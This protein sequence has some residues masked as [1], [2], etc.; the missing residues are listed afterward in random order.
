M[1]RRPTVFFIVRTPQGLAIHG[2]DL[3]RGFEPEVADPPH[4]TGFKFVGGNP[5]KDPAKRIVRGNPIRQGQEFFKPIV[6]GPAKRFNTHPV[7]GTAHHGAERDD[8]N[9]D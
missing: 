9:I 7:I 3:A 6:L 4:E 2:D 1:N 8:N 5:G